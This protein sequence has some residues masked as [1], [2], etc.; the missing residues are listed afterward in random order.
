M[1][2][3]TAFAAITAC[4]FAVPRQDDSG[5][6]MRLPIGPES[7]D[8]GVMSTAPSTVSGV[9]TPRFGWLRAVA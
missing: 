8:V 3:L 6:G 7:A 4:R 9:P 5:Y 2:R 1:T